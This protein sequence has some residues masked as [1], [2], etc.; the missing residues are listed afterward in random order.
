MGHEFVE[1]AA[2][3][4]KTGS[5]ILCE[6]CQTNRAAISTLNE[7]LARHEVREGSDKNFVLSSKD[8][9]VLGDIV[10]WWRSG[11][12][13]GG[14]G[15]DDLIG[16][17]EVARIEAAVSVFHRAAVFKGEADLEVS[18]TARTAMAFLRRQFE[19]DVPMSVPPP[20]G[21]ITADM[22]WSVSPAQVVSTMAE[23]MGVSAEEATRIQVAR[24]REAWLKV[25]RQ[26][27]ATEMR[28]KA[29][30]VA[31]ALAARDSWG[32][33]KIEGFEERRVDWDTEPKTPEQLAALKQAWMSAPE[34][35]IRIDGPSMVAGAAERLA[36][37]E[38]VGNIEETK[39]L[40]REKHPVEEPDDPVQAEVWGDAADHARA[41]QAQADMLAGVKPMLQTIREMD[42][43]VEFAPGP[44]G[45]FGFMKSAVENGDPNLQVIDEP[46][47][48]DVPI[49]AM[50]PNEF[51]ERMLGVSLTEA[52]VEVV[53]VGEKTEAEVLVER[54]R[55]RLA[56]QKGE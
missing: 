29:E 22:P 18:A 45:L 26:Q 43:P 2:C 4:A 54:V 32:M 5:P 50:I 15:A 20:D 35:M 12:A 49:D 34:E 36:S 52:Q 11:G 27:D 23:R 44:R 7:R 33:G 21:Q 24:E 3:R 25:V 31:K 14:D 47:P 40:Y 48:I 39:R 16:K 56:E 17:V 37:W 55:R 41:V 28:I 13:S 38:A 1:C 19:A 10:A 30:D 9:E 46:S 42:P 53:K 51:A 8:R 6:S